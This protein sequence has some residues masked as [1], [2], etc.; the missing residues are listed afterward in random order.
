MPYINVD[1]ENSG[2]THSGSDAAPDLAERVL[3]NQRRLRSELK[4]HYDFIVC[5]G[6]A[7]TLRAREMRLLSD[8]GIKYLGFVD[9]KSL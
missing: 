4:P 2:D 8:E 7:P 9:R 6:N 5:G 1:K 3:L